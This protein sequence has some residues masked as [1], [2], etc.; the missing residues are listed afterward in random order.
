MNET[1]LKPT[2][3]VSEL[4][5]SIKITTV[6]VIMVKGRIEKK[7]LKISISDLVSA[8]NTEREGKKTVENWAVP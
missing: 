8:N 5:I 4:F 6:T 1:Y 3:G 2:K 7:T